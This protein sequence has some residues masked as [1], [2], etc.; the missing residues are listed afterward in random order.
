MPIYAALRR[1]VQRF[2][3][4]LTAASRIEIHLTMKEKPFQAIF[5]QD[6]PGCGGGGAG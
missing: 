6:G 2:L 5:H 4:W 1:P 3:T